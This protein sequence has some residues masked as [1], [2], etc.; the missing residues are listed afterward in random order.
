MPIEPLD[1]GSTGSGG[2]IDVTNW[3]ALDAPVGAID[4]INT[5]FTLNFTPVANSVIVFKNGQRLVLSLDYTIVGTQITL[6]LAPFG[7]DTITATYF[8]V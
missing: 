4:G 8:K 2:T 5:I 6:N 1:G 7:Q 3:V